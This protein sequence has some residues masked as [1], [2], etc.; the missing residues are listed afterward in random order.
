VN[1]SPQPTAPR[2]GQRQHSASDSQF[3]WHYC[4]LALYQIVFR[5]DQNACTPKLQVKMA[6]KTT[7]ISDWVGLKI[8]TTEEIAQHQLDYDYCRVQKG[9]SPSMKE[10]ALNWNVSQC[11]VQWSPAPVWKCQNSVIKCKSFHY[12]GNTYQSH[13]TPSS[14]QQFRSSN[15]QMFV[16]MAT[17]VGQIEMN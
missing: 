12:Y 6:G 5:L 13:K 1:C 9:S 3:T 10:S 8:N 17:W 14:E 16:A 2:R 11:P 7:D 4:M 15:T